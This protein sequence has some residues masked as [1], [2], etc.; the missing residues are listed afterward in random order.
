MGAKVFLGCL[1]FPFP[2][3][4]LFSYIYKNGQK[5]CSRPT[6]FPIGMI[7]KDL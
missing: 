6:R 4:F 3:I 7:V 1:F 5:G 2:T